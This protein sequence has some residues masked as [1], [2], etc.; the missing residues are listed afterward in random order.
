MSMVYCNIQKKCFNLKNKQKIN[1]TLMT[2]KTVLIYLYLILLS[3]CLTLRNKFHLVSQKWISQI[4]KDFV[5]NLCDQMILFLSV[6]T[7]FD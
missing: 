5:L 3:F 2:S 1:S 7:E 4:L 6:R